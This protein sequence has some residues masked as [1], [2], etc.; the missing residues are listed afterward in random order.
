MNMAKTLRIWS[1]LK[2]RLASIPLAA[3]KSHYFQLLCEWIRAN[4]GGLGAESVGAYGLS[5]L[6]GLDVTEY[7]VNFAEFDVAEEV[8]NLLR[9]TPSSPDVVA[10]FLRDQ[11]WSLAAL[12]TEIE[13]PR[14]GDDDLRALWDER[15]QQGLVLACDLCGWMQKQDGAAAPGGSLLRPARTRELRTVGLLPGGSVCDRD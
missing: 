10:M 13:C 3:E 2:E 8:D 14:C 15:D 4:E 5:W 9:Q 12:R 11:L 6:A 7:P 1:G